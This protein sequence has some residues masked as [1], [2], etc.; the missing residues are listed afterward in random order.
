MNEIE[1]S[2]NVYSIFS[3]G[4]RVGNVVYECGMYLINDS[5]YGCV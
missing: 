3:V 4:K 2:K 5:H 1:F